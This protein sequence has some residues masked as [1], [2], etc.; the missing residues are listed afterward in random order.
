MG[1]E[2]DD[3]SQ[4]AGTPPSGMGGRD[5]PM[6]DE[7]ALGA[8]RA[9]RHAVRGTLP[10]AGAAHVAEAVAAALGHASHAALLAALGGRDPVARAAGGRVTE[11]SAGALAARLAGFGASVT[12]AEA[13][14]AAAALERVAGGASYAA[15]RLARTFAKAFATGCPDG[16]RIGWLQR[17]R[18]L[19]CGISLAMREG[20][21]ERPTRTGFESPAMD[22]PAEAVRRL[23]RLPPGSLDVAPGEARRTRWRLGAEWLPGL[24]GLDRLEGL[25]VAWD[26]GWRVEG[27]F[28]HAGAS[29]ARTGK[30]AG[31]ANAGMERI[32]GSV[33]G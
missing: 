13:D 24:E 6:D 27:R 32:R 21:D 1:K 33:C 2:R 16:L 8:L 7:A 19:E 3:A 10:Q 29:M 15:D 22:D 28:V 5:A 9:A 23:L 14:A 26:G 4:G 25:A 20:L 18:R 31:D 12:A 17:G 11:A 30:M